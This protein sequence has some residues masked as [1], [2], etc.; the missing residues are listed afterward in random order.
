MWLCGFFHEID[1]TVVRIERDNALFPRR[2][3]VK[4]TH[5]KG[6]EALPVKPQ[7]SAEIDVGKIISIDDEKI[8]GISDER[9]VRRNCT[10]T[11]EQMLL[12][13]RHDSHAKVV[14]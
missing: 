14:A 10:R 8:A 9:P 2:I 13:G 3:G 1:D 5:S 6:A 4:Q 12:I 7:H 11:A